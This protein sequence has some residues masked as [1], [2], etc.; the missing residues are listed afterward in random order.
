MITTEPEFDDWQRALLIASLEIQDD[1]G[2][3]GESLPEAFSPDADPNN[4][5][6]AYRFTAD[7][8]F[9]NQAEK[10]VLDAQDAFR[11]Q[12]PDG[13]AGHAMNGLHWTAR[14]VPRHPT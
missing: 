2:R 3:Y 6:G 1:T 13:D 4:P 10:A 5:D 12:L 7:G 11:K 14:K 9:R 8:P